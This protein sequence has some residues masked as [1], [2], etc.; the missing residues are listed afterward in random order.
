VRAFVALAV[1]GSVN[2]IALSL[3]G[4]PPAQ[5][6][7]AWEGASIS[8][9]AATRV[10][11]EPARRRLSER[12]AR[13]WPPGPHALATAASVAVG[14]YLND[15]ARLMTCFVGPDDSS[16]TRTRAAALP[17]RLGGSGVHV[18]DLGSLSPRERTAVDSALL[19]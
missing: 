8:G 11:D 2:G 3:L 18:E 1:D 16:G 13:A 17:T 12:A 7:L 10:L 4:I 9:A 19:L 5:L 6:V 15:T 14:A